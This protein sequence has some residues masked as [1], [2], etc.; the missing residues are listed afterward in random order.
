MLQTY[1]PH[2]QASQ[3]KGPRLGPF[4]WL[5]WQGKGPG[6]EVDLYDTVTLTNMSPV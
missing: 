5:A 3:A 2:C 6:N 4:V 1:S